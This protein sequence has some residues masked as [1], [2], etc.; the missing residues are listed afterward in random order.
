MVQEKYTTGRSVNFRFYYTNI[1]LG[2]VKLGFWCLWSLHIFK[3][4]A[5]ASKIEK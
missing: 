1:I 4:F 3:A 2:D 5:D